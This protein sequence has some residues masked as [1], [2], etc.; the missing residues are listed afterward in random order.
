[1]T[2]VHLQRA[3]RLVAHKVEHRSPHHAKVLQYDVQRSAEEGRRI[4]STPG[5]TYNYVPGSQGF[6]TNEQTHVHGSLPGLTR[7]SNNITLL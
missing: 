4:R 2:D 7:L 1:M 3:E 6:P 5:S